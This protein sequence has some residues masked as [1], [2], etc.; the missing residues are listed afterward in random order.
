MSDEEARSEEGREE[1]G[2]SGGERGVLSDTGEE[3]GG[4]QIKRIFLLWW[5]VPSLYKS[6]KQP[7]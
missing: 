6:H 5:N 1:E 3:K 2:G 4:K 7:S